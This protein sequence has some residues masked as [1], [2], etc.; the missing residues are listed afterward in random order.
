MIGLNEVALVGIVLII[1]LCWII[2][3]RHDNE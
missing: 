3:G 1:T 2:S